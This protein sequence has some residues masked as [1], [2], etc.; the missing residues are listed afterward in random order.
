MSFVDNAIDL[1]WR[2]F[3]S[4]LDAAVVTDVPRSVYR[5]VGHAGEPCKTAEP[6][7]MPRRL[8]TRR[9]RMNELIGALITHRTADTFRDILGRA[10]G[11]CTQRFSQGA[12]TCCG[13]DCCSTGRCR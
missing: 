9:C 6:T 2:N 10:R 8:S 7:E 13:A 4:P 12:A 5:C 11:R 1:L 3:S